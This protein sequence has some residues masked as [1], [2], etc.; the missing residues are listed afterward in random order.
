MITKEDLQKLADLSRLNLNDEELNSF[1]SDLSG[2]ID[3]VSMLDGL[4]LKDIQPTAQVTGLMN[5]FREDKTENRSQAELLANREL[6]LKNAANVQ[7]GFIAVPA[8]FEDV[9]NN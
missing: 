7:D 2:L 3:Y 6:F 8:V 5:V 1:E 4:E 9:D